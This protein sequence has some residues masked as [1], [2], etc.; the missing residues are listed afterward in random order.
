MNI[1]ISKLVIG[2]EVQMILLFFKYRRIDF[3]LAPYNEWSCCLLHFTG[4]ALFNR[5]LRLVAKKKVGYF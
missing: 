2:G 1:S 4:S 3:L 5:N